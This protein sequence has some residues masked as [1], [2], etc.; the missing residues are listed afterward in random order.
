MQKCLAMSYWKLEFAT[1]KSHRNDFQKNTDFT[2]DIFN[3]IKKVLRTSPVEI[4]YL[5]VLPFL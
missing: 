2:M 5:D 4:P 3:M 1:A